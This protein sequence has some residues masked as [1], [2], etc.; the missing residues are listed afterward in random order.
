MIP[1]LVISPTPHLEANKLLKNENL[2]F[3]EKKKQILECEKQAEQMQTIP[4]IVCK[5]PL[6]RIKTFANVVSIK[7]KKSRFMVKT[8]IVYPALF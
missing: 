8:Y 1:N 5:I 7:V 3:S 6:E 4:S 2:N